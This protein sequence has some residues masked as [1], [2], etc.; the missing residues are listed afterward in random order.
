MRKDVTQILAGIES[1]NDPQGEKLIVQRTT[2]LNSR[3]YELL[4]HQAQARFDQS[5]TDKD[6]RNE[7]KEAED[8]FRDVAKCLG[9]EYLLTPPKPFE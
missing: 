1:P 6:K 3:V 4:E 2:V 5:L 9:F 8:A 7:E